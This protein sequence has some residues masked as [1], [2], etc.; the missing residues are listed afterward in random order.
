MTHEAQDS[1]Q[2]AHGGPQQEE[3]G[4]LASQHRP[5]DRHGLPA[6]VA[7]LEDLSAR[8]LAAAPLTDSARTRAFQLRDHLAG[9]VRVRA[10]SLETPLVVL[11]LGPTGAGKSTLFNT[12]VGRAASP[13]SVLRPTTRTAIVLAHPDDV[14]ALREGS[15]A[16]LDEERLRYLVDPEVARGL[17]LIDAPDIDSVETA[18]RELAEALVE[19]A[20]LCL[21]VTTASRYADRV[22]WQILDRV[23]E[24]G[25]PLTVVVNRLPPGAEDRRDVLVDV[26]RLFREAGLGGAT[27][28]RAAPGTPAVGLPP[29]AGE[30]RAAGKPPEGPSAELEEPPATSAEGRPASATAP[31]EMVGIAEGALEPERE[32]LD[33]LAIAP[34]AARIEHLRSD[35]EA[36]L[37]LAA[38]A[39]AG[40]LAGLVP[41]IHAIAD[42]AAHEA[43]DATAVLR[44]AAMIHESEL[45]QLRAD[46]G[47]GTFL[48]EEALRHWQSYVGA[49]DVTR[50][51][52]KGI[53]AIRGAIAAVLRPTRAPV[54]EIRDATTDDL[55][56]VARSHAAEAARRTASAWSERPEVAQA[57]ADDAD[58]WEPS[59]DF[60]GRLRERLDGWIA[61]IAQDISETGDAKR[62]LARGASVGVN[63]VGVGVMLATFIHTA[64]LTGAEVGVAAATAFVNQKLLSALFGEAAMVELIDRARARLNA[65]LT[66]TFNEERARFERLVSTPGAL[67]ELS[68]ELH[69]AADE[70]RAVS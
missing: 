29:A 8:R 5:L 26:Q 59:A 66:E 67:D 38:Q 62:R 30:P 10:R 41:L 19:V 21:F 51:F 13:T 2:Q 7:R 25:L 69:R 42:D 3:R 50:F 43:I 56:A 54:A 45:E 33:P 20:D 57:V 60:D 18:N 46:L 6:L 61:S 70:V 9:H 63:A 68:A 22:P 16:R 44:S 55:V 64:G 40:S 48:R 1:V 39:L 14:P 35:R 24:R 36:R 28:S 23:H 52:S 58:L 15:L 11:L 53:G 12:L 49:D 37:A 47:R 34:I 27:E 32:S 17:A 65:A 31:I 4:R